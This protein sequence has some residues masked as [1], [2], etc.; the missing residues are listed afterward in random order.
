MRKLYKIWLTKQKKQAQLAIGK[1]VSLQQSKF[2]LKSCLWTGFLPHT[3]GHKK[4]SFSKGLPY[5][6]YAKQ[7]NDVKSNVQML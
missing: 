5:I 2:V 3:N 4:Q 6:L 7:K 1:L